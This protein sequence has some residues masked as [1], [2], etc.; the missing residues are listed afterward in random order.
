MFKKWWVWL[1]AIVLLGFLLRL[2]TYGFIKIPWI[3]YDEFTYLDTA[4]Q[5][6]RGHFISAF[7][8]DQLYPAGWPLLLAAFVGF[9]HDP[10]VQY[11]AALVVT[12]PLSSLV[13]VF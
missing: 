8:R 13:P 2:I 1:V 11:K 9:F 7:T 6:V 4:R 5:I 10:Y 3:V 12:M